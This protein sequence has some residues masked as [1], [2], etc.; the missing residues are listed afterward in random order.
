MNLQITFRD[1]EGSGANQTYVE[2]R[3]ARALAPYDRAISTRVVVARPH[4]HHH[5]GSSFRVTIHVLLPG[6]EIVV[7][8]R[9]GASGHTDFHAAIDDAFD[10]LER[11]LRDHAGKRTRSA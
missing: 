4:H 10:D 7:S 6:E 1:F 9:D 5:Q 11:Q 8:P 3:A 2:K